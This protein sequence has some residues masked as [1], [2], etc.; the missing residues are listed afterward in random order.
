MTRLRLD[1]QDLLFGTFLVAVA[2][3]AL[4]ATRTLSVGHAADMGPGY[5]PRV[6]SLAL[7]GFGLFFLGRSARG[8]AVTIEAVRL[9]PLLAVLAAVGVFA[10]TAERL[11]LAIA[12]VLTVLLA[13]LATRE[14]RPLESIGFA[15]LLSALAALLFIKVLALPVPLWPR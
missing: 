5:M 15:L 3:G 13:G 10:L 2:A 8:V 14:T 6:V 1:W 7:F 12:S 9:R 11:G 4:Y